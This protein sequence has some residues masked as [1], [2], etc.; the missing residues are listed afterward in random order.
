MLYI[1]TCDTSNA[2]AYI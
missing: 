2:Y 1:H